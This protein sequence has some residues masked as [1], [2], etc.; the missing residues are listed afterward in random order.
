MSETIKREVESL[1]G[2]A[3]VVR[4]VEERP[5]TE[6]AAWLRQDQRGLTLCGSEAAARAGA[7]LVASSGVGKDG[8]WWV[9][10]LPEKSRN[11]RFAPVVAR[12]QRYDHGEY[13]QW[14]E[15]DSDL[16]GGLEAKEAELLAGTWCL[17]IPRLED[18]EQHLVRAGKKQLAWLE[19]RIDLCGEVWQRHLHEAIYAMIS[20]FVIFEEVWGPDG[21]CELQWR[22]PS[23]VESWL[24]D[25]SKS[26]ILGV[27]LWE[28]DRPIPANRLLHYRWGSYGIDPEGLPLLRCLG[29]LIDLKQQLLRLSGVAF[30]A[31]GVPIL[32]IESDK[33]GTSAG[34]DDGREVRVL[35][36]GSALDRKV[37]KLKYGHHIVVVQASGQMPDGLPL[38]RYVDEKIRQRMRD[39][40]ALLGSGGKGGSYALAEQREADKLRSSYH[41]ARWLAST[42]S[43]QVIRRMMSRA[44]MAPIKPGLWPQLKYDLGLEDKRVQAADL[45]SLASAG[46]VLPTPRVIEQI[47]Q[48]YDLDTSE[49][50]EALAA[51]Q[52]QQEAAAAAAQ[53]DKGRAGDKKPGE[54]PD[55][56]DKG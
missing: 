6:K 15:S 36:Q 25:A 8:L 18:Q 42:Y 22:W 47:H 54:A 4:A 23:Q 21:S 16:Q 50:G 12:G 44:G 11:A 52:A 43:T 48:W 45:V 14:F 9:N 10:G 53:Q 56:D 29:L 38:I 5:T 2:A 20:G 30:S 39:D 24:L 32:A 40:A 13:W 33:E 35:S 41:V 34:G 27:K 28:Q 49:L 3:F 7:E 46:L 37:I 1:L 55:E 17:E 19:D 26:K 51:R 31:F